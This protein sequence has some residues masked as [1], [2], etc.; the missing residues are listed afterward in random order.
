MGLWPAERQHRDGGVPARQ[1][2]RHA[3][4]LTRPRS[5]V[6]CRRNRNGGSRG[7]TSPPTR[8]GGTKRSGIDTGL[9]KLF[10]AT[11]MVSTWIFA[12]NRPSAPMFMRLIAM[13]PRSNSARRSVVRVRL[14]S[15]TT[16]CGAVEEP[17]SLHIGPRMFSM[18]RRLIISRYAFRLSDVELTCG[19]SPLLDG[20]DH[21]AK[22]SLLASTSPH[23]QH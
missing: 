15:S 3:V 10:S 11:A 6:C 9:S 12:A 18:S 16:V 8:G 20:E 21:Q 13:T 19:N 7:R 4:Q 2:R 14:A 5:L 23:W 22:R 17:T 1:P